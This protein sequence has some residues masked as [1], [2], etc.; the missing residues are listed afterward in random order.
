MHLFD[1]NYIPS[2]II[3]DRTSIASL[4]ADIGKS[5]GPR[6]STGENSGRLMKTLIVPVLHVGR[7]SKGTLML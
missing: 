7:P 3:S 4:L 2:T 6:S 1:K 5:T